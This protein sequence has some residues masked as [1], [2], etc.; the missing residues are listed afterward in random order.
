MIVTL[1][2]N[3]AIDVTYQGSSLR[4]GQ[5]HRVDAPRRRAGGKGVNT[6]GVLARMGVDH[7]CAAVIDTALL[8]WW[9]RELT[10]RRIEPLTVAASPPYRTRTT[11]AHV[12]EEG[13]A[14]L[15]NEAGTPPPRQAWQDVGHRARL[16]LQEPGTGRPV[17]AISGSLAA[18]T[19]LGMLLGL[20][21][22]ALAGGAAVIVDGS[23]D[24]LGA[25]LELGPTLV[26]P[27]AA[28]A[29]ETTGEHDPYAAARVLVERGASAAMVSSGEEGA[30]LHTGSG[31][32][33]ARP[34]RVLRGNPT[35]AGDAATAAIAARL[36][37]TDLDREPDAWPD[38]LREAIAWSGASVLADLAGDLDVDAV[39]ELAGA[40]VIER[41]DSP[42][43]TP[44][45]RRGS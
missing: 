21:E 42:P 10:A 39:P 23:G 8:E 14:T 37:T 12:D 9:E 19:D 26:R 28:E 40:A 31:T 17:L 44:T 45:D 5:S 11:I 22:D 30:Y 38:L 29:A 24:W 1:T 4:P 25:V 16:A 2:P 36:A 7:L 35:G 34:G 32:W 6:A 20:V 3:P 41:L 43:P 27:N 15:L 13:V 33:R 18:G